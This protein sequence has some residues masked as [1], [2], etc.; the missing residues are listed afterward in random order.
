MGFCRLFDMPHD[1]VTTDKIASLVTITES[2]MQSL[3]PTNSPESSG[4]LGQAILS[5][6][7]L[8]TC[9]HHAR[10]QTRAD[11]AR[12]ALTFFHFRSYI[13]VKVSHPK[14]EDKSLQLGCGAMERVAGLIDEA[15][16]YGDQNL[17][18]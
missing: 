9:V 3:K 4:D 12:R 10:S 7:I 1:T 11:R 18:E 17:S 14:G 5:R 8:H 2:Y 16:R 13:E 6:M 15:M